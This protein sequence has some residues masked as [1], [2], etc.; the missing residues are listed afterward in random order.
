MQLLVITTD[1]MSKTYD[2]T[3]TIEEGGVLRIDPDD[4][5]GSTIWLSPAVWR[6]V[7]GSGSINEPSPIKESG[8]YDILEPVLEA[9][10]ES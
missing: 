9:E 4:K 6:E 7:N 10:E 2:G 1:G 5:E 8:D 3:P